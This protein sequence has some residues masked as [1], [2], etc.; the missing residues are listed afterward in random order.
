[1]TAARP[2]RIRAVL[3]SSFDLPL[4]VLLMSASTAFAQPAIEGRVSDAQGAPVAGAT[5]VA[6]SGASTPV[7]AL[8][9]E[10]G[11][12]SLPRLAAGRY[13]LTATAPGLVGE[14]RGVIVGDSPV[15]ADMT[16]RV[17]AVTETLIVSATA[18][19]QPLSRTADAVTVISR[20]DLDA[21]QVTSLGAALSVVPGLTVVRSGGPGT[22][23]SIFP[24]GGE[25]D[26]TLVLVDG[27]RANAFGGGI[28]LSQVPISDV[29]RIEV[30]RGP[31]SARYGADA[32]GGVIQI[33]TRHGGTPSAAA[34][35][36]TGTRATRRAV[37][38]TT[39]E[40]GP[41]RWQAGG[42]YFRDE[43]FTGLA[44]ASR[45]AVSNDDARQRQGWIGGGWRAARGTDVQGTFR[46]VDTDRGA[47]GP[48][49]S[50]PARRFAGV[51][52]LAR[53]TTARRAGGVRI[54]HP[55]TGPNS[56]VRQ[57]VDVDV[58]DQDLSF[59]NAF[60]LS[61]AETRR[62]HARVQ[63]DA[64]LD[65]GFSA[66][67]GVEWLGEQGRSTFVTAGAGPVPVER[68]VIG[69][70]GE[71][72]WDAHERFSVQAG[73]RA[74][75]ITRHALPGDPSSFAPRPE[76]DARTV[77]SINPK[78]SVS[79]LVSPVAPAD[80]ARAW[81]RL[82]VAAGTGIRPPDVFETAFTDN[83]GLKPERSRSVEAGVTQTFAAGAVQLD[84]TTFLNRYDDLIVAVGSLRD[85]SRYRTDNVSN[86]RSRG[87][88][89]SAA[90]RAAPGVSLRTAYT[91]LDTAILAVDGA[92]QAPSPYRVGD[93]LLRRPRHH[94]STALTWS[95][96]R[97]SAFATLDARGR[98]L[99]AEP[100]F[101]PGGGLFDNPGR[102]IFD[103]GAS[104][105]VARGVHVFGRGLN[106]FDRAY[107]DVLG[108][109]SP[110]RTAFAGVRLVAR[111]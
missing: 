24:R 73:I 110:G 19:E 87:L 92:A 88:E 99:D 109:P 18:I 78:A 64:V 97:W 45:E 9:R 27:V 20:D 94:V 82:R 43:G 29:E 25:S 68:R 91:L 52:R 101:G 47:P 13:D 49:G 2:A 57:R 79:W 14:L 76:F 34:E 81:T 23:T 56:R 37:A 21:R 104:V 108:Y 51:D 98:T 22:V 10:S 85:V 75:H 50:D 65:A 28:D 63:T 39:G 42:D 48:F 77:V 67:G 53:G 35:F 96:A 7:V 74:E 103:S 84:A 8:T 58:A 69:S 105:R 3:L 17:T 102:A 15:R 61:E 83:P 111:R 107:E 26:Y 36:E 86:A 90:W 72:R 93:R 30:V 41:W 33:V 38:S 62:I 40:A 12:F 55:W 95:G 60:G 44:P 32:I 71:A 4:I 46:Y 31:Q 54:V 6:V 66:S 5:V 100:A 1:M 106:L 89:L 70:F 11:D 16:L 80:G 59:L